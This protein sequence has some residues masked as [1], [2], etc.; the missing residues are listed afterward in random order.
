MIVDTSTGEIFDKPPRQKWDTKQMRR[1]YRRYRLMRDIA[2]ALSVY[3]F[4]ATII[5]AA[6]IQ[7]E[8]P[9]N[10][11]GETARANATPPL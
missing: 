4:A 11:K 8:P 5:I 1:D 6:L 10:A 7:Q 2:I 9:P 3:S